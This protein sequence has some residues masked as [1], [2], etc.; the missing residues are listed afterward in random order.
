ME[1]SFVPITSNFSDMDKLNTLAK[2][3]FLLKNILHLMSL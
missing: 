1:L 3:A 2:E